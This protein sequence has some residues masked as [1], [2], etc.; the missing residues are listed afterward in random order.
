MLRHQLQA[1]GWLALRGRMR[2]GPLNV[3]TQGLGVLRSA[4][5]A[6][7][8]SAETWLVA[9]AMRTRLRRDR[10]LTLELFDVPF[11]SST[12]RDRSGVKER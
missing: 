4:P 9:A 1:D 12:H 2:T 7:I 11:A 8:A 10:R 5:E 6:A 3:A